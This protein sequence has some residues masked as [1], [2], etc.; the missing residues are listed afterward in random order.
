PIAARQR[1]VRVVRDGGG[2]AVAEQARVGREIRAVAAAQQTIERGAGHFPR[3]VPERDVDTGQRVDGGPA[4]ADPVELSL[5]LVAELRDMARVSADAQR[6][7]QRVDGGPRRREDAMTERLAPSSDA[8]VGVDANEQ[9]VDASQR[10]PAQHGRRA[11]DQHRQ[12]EDDRLDPG[13]LHALCSTSSG[14]AL[15]DETHERIVTGEPDQVKGLGQRLGE[16]RAGLGLSCDVENAEN[17]GRPLYLDDLD[18]VAA[19]VALA[20]EDA[21]DHLAREIYRWRDHRA[22]WLD[23]PGPD[24]EPL[25]RRANDDAGRFADAA[26]H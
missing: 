26:G 2:G 5:D 24:H 7:E 13:D 15:A 8:L 6:P 25:T 12:V 9:Q 20:Q 4:A 3:D 22:D 10:A 19:G 14:A 17:R 23:V 21:H 1:L 18:L 11:V 16:D